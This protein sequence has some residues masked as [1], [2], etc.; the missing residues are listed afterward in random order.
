MD[1]R[2]EGKEPNQERIMRVIT[3]TRNGWGANLHG[4]L[5]HEL[6]DKDDVYDSKADDTHPEEKGN[7]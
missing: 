4:P 5:R 6:A 3:T 7:E 1:H 2:R